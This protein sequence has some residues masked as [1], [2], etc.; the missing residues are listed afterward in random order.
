MAAPRK[1][2]T[3]PAPLGRY[4][5]RFTL[6]NV[7]TFRSPVTLDFCHADGRV[8]QWTVIL[9]ENGTGKTTLLQYLAGMRPVQDKELVNMPTDKKSGKKPLPFR[10]M[11]SG[12]E[13]IHWHVANLPQPWAKPMT[14]K[15]SLEVSAP[16]GTLAEAQ[17]QKPQPLGFQFS[18]D[19]TP[20][21]R[22]TINF[23]F[24][25]VPELAFYEQFRMFG[26]GAGRH[27]AG[28][29]SPYLMSETFFK[30][31]GGSPV[32]TLFHDDYPLI[33]PEQWFL[34]LD[35]SL[36]RA[37]PEDK[38]YLQRAYESAKRCLTESLPDVSELSVGSYGFFTGETPMSLLCKVP[39][40]HRPIPFGALSVGYRT[41]AAWLT[42][43]IKR[44]HEAFYTMKEA[45]NGPS[46][47]LIDEFDLHMHPKWQRRAMAALS[48]E[49][50]NTQFI[51][52]AHSP[53]V[54][55]AADSERAKI[56]VLQRRKREDG[57]EEIV[58]A[59]QGDEAAG[60]RVD[61]ILESFYGVPPESPR[62]EE[63]T[64]ERVRLRQKDKLATA[65]KRRLAVV[66]TELKQL[67]PP[68]EAQASKDLLADLK[69]ALQ[70]A[71]GDK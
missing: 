41:M 30:N 15:V 38:I 3:R 63:L 28:S 29:N 21:G 27:I 33:S 1:K 42:D 61:Q 39:Y 6:Q 8:A 12:E 16:A 60:W 24:T 57:L 44:M 62:F 14:M 64:K 70:A 55:Q 45:D 67:T 25:G 66:E 4:L 7:R 43:F 35:H 17:T 51:V 59:D 53:L 71:C 5:R 46:V 56:I 52:T 23:T 32:S 20:E 48:K 9:G 50:P 34:S 40:S 18:T 69:Q 22:P 36:A 68:D 65:E 19:H 54:V 58:V 31:G 26:Y 37:R 10:P 49:F 11:V 13:W 47:V 2:K